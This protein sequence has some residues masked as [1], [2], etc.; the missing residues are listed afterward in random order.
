MQESCKYI[1]DVKRVA[2]RFCYIRGVPTDMT[3]DFVSQALLSMVEAMNKYDKSRDKGHNEK[4]FVLQM[5]WYRLADYYRR[6]YGVDRGHLGQY[7]YDY[8]T[9]KNLMAL[10]D[11]YYF[12][13]MSYNGTEDKVAKK[14][15]CAK[16]LNTIRNKDHRN[17]VIKHFMEDKFICDVAKE[18]GVTPGA[19]SLSIIA[20]VKHMRQ[21]TCV[22][23]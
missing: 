9:K 3:E 20:A 2:G 5:V 19:V 15:L 12:P 14:D 1:P 18:R 4:S 6:E 10:E 17:D 11:A 21:M 7:R 23:C 22:F 8:H 16:L 13:E